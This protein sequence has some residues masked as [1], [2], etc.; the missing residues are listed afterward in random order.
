MT[1]VATNELREKM[2]EIFEILYNGGEVEL[3]CRSKTVLLQ[4]KLAKTKNKII[5]SRCKP[6]KI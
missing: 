6:Q 5:S 4:N 1:T 3:K 2:N